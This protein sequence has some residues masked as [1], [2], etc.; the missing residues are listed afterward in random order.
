MYRNVRINDSMEL[1]E[2]GLS[3]NLVGIDHQ[4]EF[5]VNR[6]TEMPQIG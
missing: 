6:A 1:N 2:E 5:D 4:N 3:K